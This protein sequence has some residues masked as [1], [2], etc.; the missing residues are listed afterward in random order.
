MLFHELNGRKE[1]GEIVLR[2]FLLQKMSAKTKLYVSRLNKIVQEE[3]ELLDKANKELFDKYAIGEGDNKKLDEAGIE[4]F[5]KESDELMK[6]E[7]E[8]QVAT[9]WSTDLSANDL[10]SIETEEYY[11]IFYSL[12]DNKD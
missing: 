5:N 9:L 3:I 12:V 10:A 11:P 2:G 7:V 4:L 8:I 1:N 6:S